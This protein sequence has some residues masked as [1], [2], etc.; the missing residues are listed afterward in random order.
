M[1]TAPPRT[2]PKSLI[3][4]LATLACFMVILDT[5]IVNV[6]I[7]DIRK[8]LGASLSGLQWV[9]DGYGLTFAAFLLSAGALADRVGPRRAF[10][11]GL[12]LF[13]LASLACG[14]APNLTTLVIARGA[15]GAGAAL[16]IPTSLSLISRTFTERS[17]RAQALAIWGG[18]GGGLAM[19]A[20]PLFGGILTQAL[21]WRSVFLINVP[22][23]VVTLALMSRIGRDEISSEKRGIDLGGQLLAI[24]S[25]SAA[26]FFFIEGPSI[27]WGSPSTLVAG[28]LALVGGFA[29]LTVERRSQEPMLPLIL[30]RIRDFSLASATGFALNFAFYGQLF[31]LNVYLQKGLGL[32]PA[33]AGLR[34]LPETAGALLFATVVNRAF[35]KVP[36]RNIVIVGTAIS[37]V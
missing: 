14:L 30:F 2:I 21:G 35:R 36:P 32:S 25:L 37:A 4:V 18:I 3:L 10:T 22:V 16:L 17:E 12:I 20:G 7:E 26:T 13:S 8:N 5:T 27:G 23:G 28:V 6:A 29:F 9:I 1:S 34:F 11:W 15:Q 33:E 19:V 31:F 24:L